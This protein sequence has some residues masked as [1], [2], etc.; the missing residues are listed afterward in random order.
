V[1]RQTTDGQKDGIQLTLWTQLD[2]LDFD[3]LALLSYNGQQLQNK[4]ISLAFHSSQV[5]L[6]IHPDKTKILK[7]NAS[8]TETA[9][10]GDNNLGEVKSLKFLG[11]MI[12]QQGGTDADVKTLVGKARASFKALMNI[13]RSHLNLSCTK[14]RLFNSNVKSVLLYGAETWRTTKTTIKKVQ[15]FIN[16]CLC[17]ILKIHWAVTISNT[18]LCERANQ[19]PATLRKP[20]TDITRQ[21][22]T[23]NP[24]GNRKRRWPKNSWRRDLEA[25]AKQTSCS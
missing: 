5:G 20:P 23:W 24:H 17:G 3:D 7:I 9:K 4:T 22:F 18:V 12:N 6:H 14:I 13:W 10:L 11:S 8:S 16:P 1:I 15:M 21:A 2:D 25:D 19:V